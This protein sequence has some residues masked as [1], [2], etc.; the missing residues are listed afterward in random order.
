L[1]NGAATRSKVKQLDAGSPAALKVARWELLSETP[2]QSLSS[3]R[4]LFAAVFQDEDQLAALNRPLSEDRQ[5]RIDQ[6]KTEEL[7]DGLT[8]RMVQEELGSASALASEIW[9]AFV[10]L[11]ALALIVEAV[12][13]LPEKEPIGETTELGIVGQRT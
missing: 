2:S 5:R 7:F 12:L 13:C 9:R 6:E 10:I 3:D 8:I 11:M 4:T 1:E